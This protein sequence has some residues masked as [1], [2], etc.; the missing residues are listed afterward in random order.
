VDQPPAGV[1][2]TPPMSL[3][4][5]AY[6]VT[7]DEAASAIKAV[8]HNAGSQPVGLDIETAAHPAEQSRLKELTLSLAAARGKLAA[9]KKAKASPADIKLSAKEVKAIEAR[10]KMA[11]QAALDPHRSSIRL[12]QLYGGGDRV[13][14]VDI[15]RAGQEALK[16]LDGLNIVAHNAQFELKHLEHAGVELGEIHCTLQVARL[17]LGERRLSLADAAAD[18][19]GVVLD[20]A[21]Q[22]SD[23]SAP[24]LT[25]PQL[26]YAAADAVAAFRLAQKMF[27][28]LG[29]QRAAYEVQMSAV[30]AVARMELRGFRLDVPAHQRLGDELEQKLCA[31]ES[32]YLD[33]CGA[34]GRDDLVDGGLPKTPR[35]KERLL[36]TL[37]SQ[38]ERGVDR[39]GQA[40][41]ARRRLRP[42][43]GGPGVRR[44]RPRACALSDRRRVVGQGDLRPAEPAANP[45][46]LGDRRLQSAVRARA[47][48]SPGGRRLFQHGAARRRRDHRRPDHDEGI[49]T[50]R[51]PACN[52]RRPGQRQAS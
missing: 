44:H 10:R 51:R 31:A 41:Q 52:H 32:A 20:K 49:P 36:E 46:H 14:V 28:T 16:L 19:L 47:G 42:D 43:A 4:I 8:A 2:P 35:D 11:E 50:W 25:R 7:A 12:A 33:A 24:N 29:V 17:L 15:A 45:A 21:E 39:G 3:P 1:A 37:L 26:E 38:D 48:Q 23:W 22:T 9:L 13:Y 27:P 6:C 18:Y 5:V 40:R 30:P 34:H